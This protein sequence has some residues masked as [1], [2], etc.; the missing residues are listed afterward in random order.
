VDRGDPAVK[1]VDVGAMEFYASAVVSSDPF[2]LA[3]VMK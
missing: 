1:T 2:G 3:K